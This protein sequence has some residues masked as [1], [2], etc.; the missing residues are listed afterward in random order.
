MST[1]RLTPSREKPSTATLHLLPC[2]IEHTGPSK[3]D[4]FFIV[5]QDESSPHLQSCF[6]GRRLVGESISI[7]SGYQGVVFQ[8]NKNENGYKKWASNGVEEE[9][10]RIREWGPKATFEKMVVW[11]HDKVPANKWK[12]VEEWVRMAN[13]LHG[14]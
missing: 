1:I 7:P 14:K 11:D 6:R 9:E 5:S 3:V 4:S 8:E 12:R 13:I 2:C 10:E